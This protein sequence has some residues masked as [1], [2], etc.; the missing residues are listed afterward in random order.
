MGAYRRISMVKVTNVK[1]IKR[2]KK[3]GAYEA[4]IGYFATGVTDRCLSAL[5]LSQ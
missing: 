4:S 2:E 5:R 3:L 1:R